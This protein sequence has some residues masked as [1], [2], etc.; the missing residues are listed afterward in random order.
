MPVARSLAIG[1]RQPGIGQPFT[2]LE[3]VGLAKRIP[4]PEPQSVTIAK[5]V[6]F[7]EQVGQQGE[8]VQ[9]EPF[10]KHVAERVHFPL[11][12][13]V[14]QSQRFALALDVA[15]PIAQP[16]LEH[17]QVGQLVGLI[18][19]QHIRQVYQPQPVA[20]CVRQVGQL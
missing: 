20:Q 18:I 16:I 15:L 4:I 10:A 2:Q 14:S 7:A 12:L 1:Q 9:Q 13:T 11:R 8:I 5:P 3:Q 17:E 19:A 6:G